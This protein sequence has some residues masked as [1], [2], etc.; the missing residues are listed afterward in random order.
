MPFELG[1][2]VARFWKVESGRHDWF[3][4]ESRDRRIMKSLSDLNG[5]DAHIHDGTIMGVLRELRNMFRKPVQQPSM[6]EMLRVYREIRA[7]K[8]KLVDE[9]RSR[10]IYSKRIFEELCIAAQTEAERSRS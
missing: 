9:S 4:C 10:T 8:Q 2:T 1:L 6:L 7:L 5:S 3:V